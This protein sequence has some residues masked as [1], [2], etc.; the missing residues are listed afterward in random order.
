VLPNVL[1]IATQSFK[2]A[3]EYLLQVTFC[4]FFFFLFVIISYI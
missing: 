1:T 4:R 2:E 3:F